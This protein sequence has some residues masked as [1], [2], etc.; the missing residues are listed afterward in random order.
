M[1]LEDCILEITH[2]VACPPILDAPEREW[3]QAREKSVIP[4]YLY[5]FYCLADYFSIDKAPRFLNDPDRMLFSFLKGLANGIR[6]SLEEA[7]ELAA[8]I[9]SDQGKGYSPFK[10]RRGERWDHEADTRRRRSFRYIIVSLASAMDQFAEVVSIFFYG[11]IGG[12]TVGRQSFAQLRGFARGPFVPEGMVVSPKEAHFQKLHTV[13]V[14]ELEV[15]GDEQQWFDL[16]HLYRNKLAHLGSPMF[17]IVGFHDR[18]GEFYSFTPN[19]WP[20]FHESEI[21]PEEEVSEEQDT[22]RRYAEECY[23]HQDIVQYSEGVL[24]RVQRLVD[25]GFQVLCATYNDFKDFDLN[26]SA[27]RSLKRKRQ[28]YS[29]RRFSGS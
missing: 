15:E 22:I 14:E 9:R 5:K 20:L 8:A 4:E 23:I 25:R 2:G 24:Y 27:L 3:T 16:L 17:P 28:H 19:R 21:R 18:T 29:F 13:L 11:D 6:E 10:K 12:L 1:K 7:H 26:E